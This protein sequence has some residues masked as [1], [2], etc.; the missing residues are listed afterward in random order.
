MFFQGYLVQHVLAHTGDFRRQG[1][2][3]LERHLRQQQVQHAHRLTAHRL[4]IFRGSPAGDQH[5]ALAALLVAV[6]L[7]KSSQ[8]TQRQP[9]E[10]FERLG[11]LTRKQGGTLGAKYLL[12]I[13]QTL[14]DS[15]R[16]L[17]KDQGAR[18]F[19]D[20]G[21]TRAAPHR[22]GRQKTFENEA[23]R[24]QPR[25]RKRSNQCASARYRHH[26]DTRC[27]RL[28]HE[29]VAGIRNQRRAGIGDQCHAVPGQQTRQK[30]I[31]LV[32]LVVLMAGRQ[33]RVD[34]KV[35]QQA[36]GMTRV[37]GRN[38]RDATE[39]FQRSRTH[40]IQVADGRGHHVKRASSGMGSPWSISHSTYLS[41]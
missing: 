21:Q 19:L 28:A 3:P 29:V 33:R 20:L 35:L 8:L 25:R 39:Y 32:A 23:I 24:W 37:F 17:I 16:R 9:L 12:H 30:A 13:L 27:T 36:N 22:L 18:L 15:M 41:S 26:S 31:A 38:Q 1:R 5:H 6:R 2:C 14:E 34:T 7:D 4:L 40:I 11:Q 10:G